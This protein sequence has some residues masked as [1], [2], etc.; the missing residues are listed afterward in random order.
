MLFLGFALPVLL[1]IPSTHSQVPRMA[2]IFPEEQK[3]LFPTTGFLQPRMDLSHLARTELPE[4]FRPVKQPPQWD[5]REHRK[6]T[7]VRNQGPCGSCYAFASVAN[8]ES[9]MLMDDIGNFDFS[10]NNAK[11]CNWYETSCDGGNHYQMASWFSK[12]G[13]VLESCD[14]YVPGDVSCNST[15]PY[16]K[17]LLD[18]RIISTNNIPP[19]EVLQSYIYNC[20]PVYT[21]L[22]AGDGNDSAWRNEFSA[23]D[24]SYTLY[25]DGS[26]SPN[27]AVL[28]VGWDDTLSHDGG[29]GAWIVKNSWGTDWGGTC[30]YGSEGGYLTIAYGS[31]RIGMWSSYVDDVKDYNENG[32]ILYYDEG[33]WTTSW[34]Y[35]D[36]TGWGLCKF[37]S[38][39]TF[40][41]T[42]VE[43]WT[44][45]ATADIDIY[46]YDSFDG[47]TLDSLLASKLNSSYDEAGYH[48]VALDSPIQIASGDNVYAVVKFTN[49]SY[50]Y[51]V[52][53]DHQGLK[54]TATT[55][56]S[57]SGT[58]GSWFDLGSAG[59]ENDVA[60]RARGVDAILTVI[61]PNGGEDWEMES[62]Q[63]LAWEFVG[64]ILSVK[65]EYSTNGGADWTT[66]ASF[67]PNDGGHPWT[68]PNT[69]STNCLLRISDASDGDPCDT[70]DAPFTLSD[71]TPP[72]QVANLEAT[73]TDTSVVLTWSPATDNIGVHRYLVYRDTTSGFTPD[74]SSSLAVSV[75]TGYTDTDANL[76]VDYYYRVSAVD[77]S[78][79]EGQ[80]SNEVQATL[81]TRIE[82]YKAPESPKSFFL[83]QNYPN[84][85]N[86]VTEIKYSLPRSCYVKLE[87]FNLLGQKVV[88]LVD[89]KQD[90]GHKSVR[91][92]ARSFASGWYF[93]RIYAHTG[94]G[95]EDFVQ[96][97]KMMIMR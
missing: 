53:A 78:G 9:K 84:P 85:F 58:N 68:V 18:W 79:N 44:N 3:E 87:V 69:P 75:D 74:S 19:T 71:R 83:M 91:W 61:S 82:T 40:C 30:G 47:S 1:L 55:Y 54:E 48:S 5:W 70:S 42:R 50:N 51:P 96:M 94:S 12:E 88:T 95:T 41:L 13:T 63:T 6:V 57:P 26:W 97:R 64:L 15:C 59:Y 7:P 81:V 43:F 16:V 29:T 28:I 23:Y 22:Y 52:V 11:E 90:A 77:S 93:C 4:R 33:G 76:G 24:G 66:I 36:P 73:S 21:T 72:S 10:E 25:Y 49:L 60:I 34:G 67:T 17:T 20:G 46:I 45:D 38:V 37:L 86:P 39:S 35:G 2:P 32:Q 89:R 65:I 31:A 14:P 62:E 8:I 80:C 56:I 27:H 92:N